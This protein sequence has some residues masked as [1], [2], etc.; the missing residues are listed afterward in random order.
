MGASLV[1]L[2]DNVEEEWLDVVVEGLVVQK[3]LCEQ[4]QVL[5]VDLFASR[6]AWSVEAQQGAQ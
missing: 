3:H 5:A 1:E 2:C 6:N 4:A